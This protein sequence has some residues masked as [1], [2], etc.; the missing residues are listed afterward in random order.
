[1]TELEG[2]TVLVVGLGESGLSATELL[3]QKQARVVVTDTRTEDVLGS[4]A[5]RARELGAEIV[6]G[7]HPIEAFTSV[8]HI[9]VS[10]GVPPLPQLTKAENAGIPVSSEVELAS[11]FLRGT[12]VAITGTNGKSTVTS[13]VGDMCAR[14]G[15]ATFV[16]GNLGQPVTRAV[17]TAA[18]EEDGI[19]VAE[20][21]S[22]Q[23]ERVRRMRPHVA[24]LLNLSDDHLDRY[25]SFAAYAEA[26]GRIFLAQADCDAAIVP[27]GD[28]PCQQLAKQGRARI[29]PFGP[30]GEVSVRGNQI[31]NGSSDFSFPLSRLQIH[32]R[33]NVQNA[34]AAA[35]TARLVGINSNDI[36]E[37]LA[38]FRGLP[39]RM[40]HVRTL[41][42]VDW[43]DDSKATN[44]GAATAAIH[45][46]E[47]SHGR[48][49]LI[50][51][52]R[53]KGS[54]YEP[55]RELLMRSG[56][57]VVTLG[58]A[59]PLLEEAFAESGVVLARAQTIEDAVRL[60]RSLSVPGDVVLLA[61]ACSSYDMFPSY[62]ARGQAFQKAVRDL[63]EQSS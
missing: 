46:V 31:K 20:V 62:V 35:L 45:G 14:S 23:L 18:A 43:V 50:A 54:S 9:V 59:A 3:R 57:A 44:V 19:V 55:M 28:E 39:H 38:E 12:L 26:K 48:I 58:E 52:G 21:S 60:S 16:G 2:K 29:H 47:H 10:P 25:P 7:E 36:V 53:H 1:M 49:V 33:H 8:D 51:G 32:G 17:G 42:G 4:R 15:R 22:F 13:L 5:K 11:W 27:A 34:C 30:G 56:R 37:A 40:E 6:L 63:P 61:P 24:V 41:D